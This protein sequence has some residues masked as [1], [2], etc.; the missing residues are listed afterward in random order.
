MTELELA[1]RAESLLKLKGFSVNR[2]ARV[3]GLSGFLHEFALIAEKGTFTLLL[4]FAEKTLD[5]LA[6]L[7]KSIDLKGYNTII[8]VR[9]DVFAELAP[10]LGGYA[11]GN[12][13]AYKDAEDFER[14]LEQ[15]LG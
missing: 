1:A 15:A 2:R 8:A 7:A 14:K 4:D 9:E 11:R 5:I 3:R 13:I 12:I 10:I 6:F